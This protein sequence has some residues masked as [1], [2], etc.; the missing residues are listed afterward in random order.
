MAGCLLAN[1]LS[2]DESKKVLLIEAGEDN[3]DPIV[4]VSLPDAFLRLFLNGFCAFLCAAVGCLPSLEERMLEGCLNDKAKPFQR[5][6]VSC[7][8]AC[9]VNRMSVLLLIAS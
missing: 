2:A 6:T 7:K 4:K 9:S 8:T 1:R 5:F 3:K